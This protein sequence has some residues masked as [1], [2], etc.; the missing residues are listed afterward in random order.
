MRLATVAR[1]L[2]RYPIQ[3]EGQVNHTMKPIPLDRKKDGSKVQNSKC[4]HWLLRVPTGVITVGDDGKRKY[5]QRSKRFEGTYKEAVEALAELASKVEEEKNP[6][7]TVRECAERYIEHKKSIEAPYNTVQTVS[8]YMRKIASKIGDMDASK[9]SKSDMRSALWSM[10]DD[11]IT[12]GTV[13]QIYGYACAMMDLAASEGFCDRG[14]IEGISLPSH[15]RKESRALSNDDAMTVLSR[16]PAEDHH[17]IAAILCITCGLRRGEACALEWGDVRDGAIHLTKSLS[18]NRKVK[19]PKTPAGIR[20]IPLSSIAS[21]ALETRKA[22]QVKQFQGVVEQTSR[23][24]VCSAGGHEL[25]CTILGQWWKRHRNKFGTDLTLHE[26][27]HSY[28]TM[29]ARAKVHPSVMQALAGHSKPGITLA[30]YTHVNMDDK[31][32]AVRS[33]DVMLAEN[34]GK[35]G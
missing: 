11:G 32:K 25:S 16:I 33:L 1:R 29:L 28:L 2:E 15:K 24:R 21:D 30:I 4:R 5:G 34:S 8:Y 20:V 17:G 10:H 3:K 22:A 13:R 31:E 27:R 19:G 18:V 35:K 9:I 6:T 7:A 26:L 12:W 23:T 14:V